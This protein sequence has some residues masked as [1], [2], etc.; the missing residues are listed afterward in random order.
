MGI[1]TKN[2]ELTYDYVRHNIIALPAHG[3]SAQ[4]VTS[5]AVHAI[6]SNVVP[7]RDSDTIILVDH[8]VVGDESVVAGT[9]I[10]AIGVM[11]SC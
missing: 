5:R 10:E 1:D 11:A 6:H 3:S 4:S 9:E 8:R 2:T 7:A